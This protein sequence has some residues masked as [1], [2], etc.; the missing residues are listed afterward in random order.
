MGWCPRLLSASPLIGRLTGYSTHTHCFHNHTRL[1]ATIQPPC[2]TPVCAAP[3][4]CPGCVYQRRR[5]LLRHA[6][7]HWY[8]PPY[9][10]PASYKIPP[11]FTP[12]GPLTTIPQ[13]SGLPLGSSVLPVTAVDCPV[14]HISR[15]PT[16]GPQSSGLSLGTSIPPGPA[17]DRPVS[18]QT[19]PPATGPLPSGLPLV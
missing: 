13:F 8:P 3:T 10:R 9:I 7:S 19:G 4:C 18:P 15:P 16:T 5:C 1:I 14:H 17:A 6:Q 11:I 12:I 2:C